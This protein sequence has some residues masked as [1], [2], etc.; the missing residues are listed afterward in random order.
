MPS[1]HNK[2]SRI[3]GSIAI[4]VAMLAAVLLAACGSDSTGDGGLLCDEGSELT[5]ENFADA[6]MR[7]WCTGCHSSDLEAGARAN[8]PANVNLDTR[9]DV[10]LWLERVEVRATGETP[11]MPPTAGPSPEETAL[12]VEWLSCGA[13]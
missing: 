4:L 9:A 10:L 3:H 13:P 11:T 6:F 7:D 2:T 5:Y 12:L 1:S 8:A